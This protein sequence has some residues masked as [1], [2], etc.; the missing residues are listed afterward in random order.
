MNEHELDLRR[1]GGVRD[2]MKRSPMEPKDGIYRLVLKMRHEQ[3]FTATRIADVLKI[4]RRKLYSRIEK[5][6]RSLRAFL[7][8]EGLRAQDVLSLEGWIE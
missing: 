2:I 3:G 8:A 6:Y 7:E 1:A 5:C 4:D